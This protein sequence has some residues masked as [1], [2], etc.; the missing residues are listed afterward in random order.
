MREFVHGLS[1]NETFDI[2][3]ALEHTKDV[4][5]VPQWSIKDKILLE[6]RHAP[7]PYSLQCFTP[8]PSSTSHVR[9]LREQLECSV[10]FIDKSIG[11]LQ[12]VSSYIVGDV[13]DITAS[14][15]ADTYRRFIPLSGRV[16]RA[17]RGG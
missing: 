13:Q 4:H 8:K 6:V 1:V 14:L 12:I 2:P 7:E 15:R 10:H 17:P 11:G 5:P 3:G 16:W 9:H